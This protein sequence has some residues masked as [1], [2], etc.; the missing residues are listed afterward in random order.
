MSLVHAPRDRTRVV[1][2]LGENTRAAFV[3]SAV[4]DALDRGEIDTETVSE[5]LVKKRRLPA[6][7]VVGDRFC[8]FRAAP[9]TLSVF[10]RVLEI[11][12]DGRGVV[13]TGSDECLETRTRIKIC[14]AKLMKLYTDVFGEDVS[15]TTLRQLCCRLSEIGREVGIFARI[16]DRDERTSWSK[17]GSGLLLISTTTLQQL[18]TEAL[19]RASVEMAGVL[20]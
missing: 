20:P 3:G 1:K 17:P 6:R 15:P 5:M 4:L 9:E 19:S 12:R 7:H 11:L 10:V 8:G 14:N 2:M 13:E 16:S 18:V